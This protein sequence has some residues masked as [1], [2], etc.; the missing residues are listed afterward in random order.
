MSFLNHIPLLTTDC[1]LER[2]R[3]FI[4]EHELSIKTSG[5]GRDKETIVKDV[6]RILIKKQIPV[7]VLSLSLSFLHLQ[8]RMQLC[9]I[10]KKFQQSVILTNKTDKSIGIS[11]WRTGKYDQKFV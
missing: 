2:I 10:S 8:H 7:T 1:K 9:Y 6:N 11:V 5:K 4:R 3:N